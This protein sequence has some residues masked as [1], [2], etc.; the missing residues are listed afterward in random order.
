[1]LGER[2]GHE[3]PIL[4]PADPEAMRASSRRSTPRRAS[5]ANAERAG[6]AGLSADWPGPG[7]RALLAA[8]PSFDVARFLEGAR[9]PIG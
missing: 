9:P 5:A 6:R 2:T 1:M 8:D 7:V 4:K 3:Q